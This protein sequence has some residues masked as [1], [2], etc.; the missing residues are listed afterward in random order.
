ALLG[1]PYAFSLGVAGAVLELIPYLGGA[2]VTI[3]AMLVALSIS[4]WLALGVLGLELLVANIESRIVYPKLVGD[5]VGLHPL[6]IIIAL[7]IG[8]EAKGIIGAL[9]AVP[10]AIVIQV[11]FERFYRFEDTAEAMEK[12]VESE[13]RKQPST[14]ERRTA[15]KKG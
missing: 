6:A 14:A 5:I 12:A 13:A 1:V 11:L 15:L 7:F 4:P 8:A 3:A 10:A 2:I 9:L